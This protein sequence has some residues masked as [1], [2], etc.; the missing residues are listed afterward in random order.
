MTPDVLFRPSSVFTP[1]PS[2]PSSVLG[3]VR[4]C[5]VTVWGK[6]SLRP[7]PNTWQMPYKF[8]SDL[9]YFRGMGGLCRVGGEWEK[10]NWGTQ[11]TNK[12]SKKVDAAPVNHEIIYNVRRSAFVLKYFIYL[13]FLIEIYRLF[14]LNVKG[15]QI[16]PQKAAESEVQR[17][18]N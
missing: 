11:R 3:T 14:K 10:S 16:K 5:D 13:T 9:I 12:Y 7:A 15:I 2:V 17:V 6:P 1:P 4:V 8:A 18:I